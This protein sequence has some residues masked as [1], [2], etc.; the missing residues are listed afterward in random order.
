MV[1]VLVA[2]TAIECWSGRH[3]VVFIVGLATFVV[4]SI[5]FPLMLFALVTSFKRKGQV[6]A[7]A[8]V[9]F[10]FFFFCFFFFFFLVF[11]F[12][13]E[14]VGY[15]TRCAPNRAT[16]GKRNGAMVL[17]LPVATPTCFALPHS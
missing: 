15:R 16:N 8:V 7:D 2:D 9:F 14:V 10:F 1:S 12:F 5:G 11:F 4:H 13:F 17:T 6:C 3:L